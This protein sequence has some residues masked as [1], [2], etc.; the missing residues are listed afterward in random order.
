MKTISGNI[1]AVLLFPVCALPCAVLQAGHPSSQKTT[2]T[3]AYERALETD[4]SITIAYE[5]LRKAQLLPLSALTKLT[6]HFTLDSYYT[7]AGLHQSGV[8]QESRD[9]SSTGFTG[10]NYRQPLL[11]MT[12]PAAYRSA[13]LSV[14]S[15]RLLYQSTIRDTLYGVVQAYYSVLQQQSLTAINKETLNLGLQQLDLARERKAVG[16]VI[17]T[18]VLRAE[19]TVA[20][21]RRALVVSENSLKLAQKILANTLNIADPDSIIVTEPEMNLKE[22]SS[23]SDSISEALEKREDL[24]VS[25]LNI[26]IAKEKRKQIIGEYLP[27]LDI[28]VSSGRQWSDP[29]F[30]QRKDSWQASIAGQIPIFTGGQRELDLKQSDYDIRVA[31]LEHESLAKNVERDV[32]QA[33]LTIHALELTLVQ[34][35]KE[36]DANAENYRVIQEQY[37]SGLATSL[38]VQQGLRDLNNSRSLLVTQTDDCE[39]ARRNLERLIGVFQEPLVREAGAQFSRTKAP[40]KKESKK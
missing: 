21:A 37:R 31:R 4:Q 39:V 11:D 2:L 18:D 19:A 38:D 7:N 29:S 3:Q 5:E 22:P 32:T 14:E 40:R 36:V 16:E 9:H 30:N 6:P 20:E 1:V 12:F 35:K 15:S 23:L 33:W 17:E 28:S 24:R 34:L 13:K 10:L 27:T 25:E 8:L 26:G